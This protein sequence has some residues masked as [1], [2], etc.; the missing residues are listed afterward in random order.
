MTTTETETTAAREGMRGLKGRNVLVTGGTSGI[1]AS[2]VDRFRAEGAAVGAAWAV[3][4]SIAPRPRTAHT[5]CCMPCAPGSALPRYE[6]TLDADIEGARAVI[7]V[8]EGLGISMTTVT[9]ELITEGVASFA[10]SFDELVDTIES[11]RKELAPA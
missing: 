8:I 2:I 10:K 6:R 3:P 11:K 1:G 7:G 5:S 9:D 4:A